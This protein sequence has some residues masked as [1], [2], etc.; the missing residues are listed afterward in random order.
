MKVA[1]VAPPFLTT[2]PATYGG[3]EQVVYDLGS[4]L[5]LHPKV[6]NVTLFAPVGSCLE[7]GGVVYETVPAK[8]DANVVW[9]DEEMRA[10]S[11]Y[12][13]LQDEFDI[14]HDHT[15]F[16]CP[17]LAKGDATI[18]HTHHGHL[19]GWNPGSPPPNGRPL[20]LIAIS[21]FMRSVYRSQ[22]FAAAYVHNGIDVSRYAPLA[23]KFPLDER[24]L[25][26]GRIAKIKQPH[27]AIDLAIDL[28]IPIDIVGGTF[29]DDLRYVEY[30][31]RRCAMS[32]GLATLHL[33]ISH[34]EK[35]R[36]MQHAQAI[37]VPS[38]FGEP[39]GLT[40]VEAMACGTPVLA[41]SDGALPEVIGTPGEVGFACATYEDMLAA[42]RE[43]GTVRRAACRDRAVA[44]FGRDRMASG[45][46]DLYERIIGG[47]AW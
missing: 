17:Y 23:G 35:V 29:V 45:Y 3:L 1:L 5:A 47:E 22:G 26:V 13:S 39:F 43:L 38:A 18:C 41:S 37:V 11:M 4:A 46:V 14:V 6:E 30:I 10:Y 21:R 34:V 25:F 28:G 8:E 36:L 16:G 20:N 15:W 33:N 42:G 9:F 19:G 2:P 7:N 27:V 32:N 24:L 12:A 31:K 40:A 44:L